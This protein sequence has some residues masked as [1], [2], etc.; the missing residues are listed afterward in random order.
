MLQGCKL[1]NVEIVYTM[2]DNLKKTG[3]MAVGQVGFKA[4]KAVK[5]MRVEKKNNE[6][7]NRL[8]KTKIVDD[9]IDYRVERER[10]DARERQK[11]V[12]FV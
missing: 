10:R 5:K 8:N 4:N 12:S 11:E 2:W 7:I 6:T 9:K 1:N 3:D